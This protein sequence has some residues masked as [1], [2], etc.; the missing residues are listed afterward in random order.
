MYQWIVGSHLNQWSRIVSR[1]CLRQYSYKTGK[2]LCFYQLQYLIPMLFRCPAH[3][4]VDYRYPDQTGKA[5]R[6]NSGPRI[7]FAIGSIYRKIN[8]FLYIHCQFVRCSNASDAAGWPP[9]VSWIGLILIESWGCKLQKWWSVSKLTYVFVS[10]PMVSCVCISNSI[11][12]QWKPVRNSIIGYRIY[13]G[14]GSTTKSG[15]SR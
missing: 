15:H 10:V 7:G 6:G 13:N 14:R 5:R 11:A 4:S 3:R 9:K 2:H 12:I 8:K 1:I